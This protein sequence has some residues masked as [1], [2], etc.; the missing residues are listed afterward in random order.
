MVRHIQKR[1]GWNTPDMI[2]SGASNKFVREL[3]INPVIYKLVPVEEDI[4]E[5]AEEKRVERKESDS[6]LKAAEAHRV[7]KMGLTN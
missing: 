1:F 3:D 7:N 5:V 6:F 4:P 2:R